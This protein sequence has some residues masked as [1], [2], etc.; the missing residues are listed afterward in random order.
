LLILVATIAIQIAC[1]EFGGHSL[2]TVPLTTHEHLICL[3]LGSLPL[4]FAP[5]FKLLVP[6]S[7]FAFL[8]KNTEASEAKQVKEE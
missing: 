3:G 7:L 2:R 4:F 6:A 8:S 1:V 5:L